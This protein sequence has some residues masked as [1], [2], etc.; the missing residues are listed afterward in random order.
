M[1]SGRSDRDFVASVLARAGS[2]R[3]DGE[4]G[5]AD[6]VELAQAYVRLEERL[7]KIIAIGDKYQAEALEFAGRLRDAL[8]RLARLEGRS[9]DGSEEKVARLSLPAATEAR[10]SER[11]A[12]DP[13]LVRVRKALEC[14][15]EDISSTDVGLLL[16][17]CEKLD[18]RL[19]KIV[20]I[21]DGYQNQLREASLRL[22][23]MARTD[24]LTGLSN[25]RDMVERLERELSRFDRYGTTFSLILFDIDGFKS[26]NDRHGHNFGDEALRTV[27]YVFGQELRRTDICGRW[28][29]EEFL[30]LCPET[31]AT[32]AFLVGEKCR[33]AIAACAME[34][35]EGEVHITM[36][37][38]VC[39]AE[40]GLT[41]DD[42]VK[43]ADDA[44]Y[45]AKA[46]GKDN[47]ISW[48]FV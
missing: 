40:N 8:E 38:G 44:L 13:L 37:G 25:R 16:R 46:A 3:F 5:S 26:V 29:G 10:S 43:R 28:G 21:S 18:A 6:L 7:G 2:R 24:I 32:E 35:K 27:A 1:K 48:P 33:R 31:G 22:E 39:G 42:L 23:F 12:E 45:R 9:A 20:R 4:E 17:R 36:S 14:A 47:I 19:E 15:D 11:R 41:I 34:S 30:V